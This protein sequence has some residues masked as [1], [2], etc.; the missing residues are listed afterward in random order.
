MT[1]GGEEGYRENEK[2]FSNVHIFLVIMGAYKYME[3]LYK[4]KQ[5][6]VLRFLLRLRCWEYRQLN[7][8]HRA[9]RPSRP[10]KARRLGYKAST[11]EANFYDNSLDLVSILRNAFNTKDNTSKDSISFKNLTKNVSR[12]DVSRTFFEVLV[13]VTKKAIT[14]EQKEHYGDIEIQMSEKLFDND[15]KMV[16]EKDRNMENHVKESRDVDFLDV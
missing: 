12:V 8:I 5:S 4:H 15:I 16:F 1:W 9:S 11:S 6:D 3:E 14:V 7:V 2:G 10:D 13:L